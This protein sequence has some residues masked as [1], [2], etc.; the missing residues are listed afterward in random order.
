MEDKKEIMYKKI[1]GGFEDYLRDESRK[2]GS[3]E[4]ISFPASTEDVKQ[5]VERFGSLK[6]CITIQG[7][8]TGVA[9]GA[10]PLEGHILNFEHMDKVTGLRF[11]ENRDAFFITVQPG[12]ILSKLREQLDS[13]AFCTDGWDEGALNALELF[14]Q[15][16][17]W[18]FPPDP[19]ET[20]ASI[21]GM[22]AC[23]ASGARSYHYGPT[24][25]Y[26]EALEVILAD[27][28]LIRLERGESKA[29]GLEF[30]LISNTGRTFAGRLPGYSMPEVKN[31][32][33]YYACSGM[34]MIDLFIG[35]EGTL[36]IIT[37]I[38]LRLIRK[39]AFVWGMTA[40]MPSE[41]TALE[42]VQAVR[43]QATGQQPVAIEFFNNNAL[44]L[45]ANMKKENPAFSEIPDIP[46]PESTA[47]YLEFHGDSEDDVAEKAMQAAE[48]LE[49]AGGNQDDTWLASSHAEMERMYHFRHAVPEAVNLII[50]MRR[51]TSPELTKLGT[52]MAVPDDRLEEVMRLYNSDLAEAGL[53]SVIFGHIGNNHVHVNILPR[54]PEEYKTGRRLYLQWADRVVEMGGTISAEHGAGKLKTALLREMYGDD[55]VGQMLEVKKIFDPECL[56]DRGSLF[57]TC[58]S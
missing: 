52:D 45:L 26:V 9:A 46:H 38:E 43:T 8:R 50:D 21:G 32:A 5:I 4:T 24:R 55:G 25:D 27:G 47:I 14:K 36:G 3:A 41:Q 30:K 17:E 28:S 18:L 20:S 34:D 10:V 33:G 56:L 1:E 51:K 23:N 7:S 57:E 2:I 37:S 58:S 53:E 19:T 48:L 11:D 15:A 31:A 13:K 49:E 39:P 54:T 16:G 42:L 35:S 12:L 6:T 44:K 29:E 22:A 40:F